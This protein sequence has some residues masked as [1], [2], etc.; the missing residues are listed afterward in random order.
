MKKVIYILFFAGFSFSG[1]A[2]EPIEQFNKSFIAFTIPEK[3]LL[4]ENVA[5]DSNDGTF[6]IGST[7]KGKIIKRTKDGLYQDFIKPKQ[8]GLHMIIGMKVDPVRKHLWVCSS[9][10]N[11]L[12]GYTKNDTIEGRPSGIFKYDL[13][14]GKLIKK[15]WVDIPGE[16]HFFNDIT[17]D[18][19]GNIY[20]TH[21][22]S[23]PKLYTIQK[24]EGR[25][26]V[27]SD[28][29]ELRYP[30]GIT[31]SNDNTYLFIACTEGIARVHIKT[32]KK[33]ILQCLEGIK[34]SGKKSVDGLYFYKNSLIGIQPD[35]NSVRKL[36]LNTEQNTIIK[37]ILIEY[38]H[39]MM[40]NPSTGVLIEDELYYIANA[41][42]GSFNKDGSLFPM[43]KLYE[44]T[45]LKVKLDDQN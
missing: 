35:E 12:I 14:T 23:K 39:P 37:T 42:F 18:T 22:F 28:L 40:N 24:D 26:K 8:D 27:L 10:G 1:I 7:R 15:Y 34:V 43:E 19:S 33:E 30:N 38:N 29:S 17:L 25:L 4:P 32:G 3:D 44:P 2:Q 9:G 6:Y 41:Q 13:T 36:V 31:I 16:V 45:I 5:Y 11:N 21:M 20:A